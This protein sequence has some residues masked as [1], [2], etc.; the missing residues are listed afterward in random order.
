MPLERVI[1]AIIP[2]TEIKKLEGISFSIVETGS[3]Q[4]CAYV[5]Y[6]LV[7]KPES[8]TRRV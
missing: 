5:Q 3:W 8:A 7:T 6:P 1:K 2:K 4:I